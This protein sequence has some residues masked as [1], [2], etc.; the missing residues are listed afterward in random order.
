MFGKPDVL[1]AFDPN[2]FEKVC[3]AEGQWPEQRFFNSYEYYKVKIRPDIFNGFSGIATENGEAWMKQR[4]A[5]NPLMLN[6]NNIKAYI[7]PID[8]VVKDFVAKIDKIRDANNEMP[9]N[10]G[11]EL[12][13]WA[14]ESI[15]VIALDRRLGVISFENQPEAEAIIQVRN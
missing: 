5:A 13:R 8:Q 11:V 14:L 9:D 1:F 7:T 2:D 10:F 12:S 4:S 3:R 15:G 6:P